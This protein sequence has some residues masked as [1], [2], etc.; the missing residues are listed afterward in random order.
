MKERQVLQTLMLVELSLSGVFVVL[1]ALLT[2]LPDLD[3]NN[4]FVLIT[5]FLAE[6]VSYDVTA[7]NDCGGTKNKRTCSTP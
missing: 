3:C 2:V 5:I 6:Q 4:I 7:S 1:Y